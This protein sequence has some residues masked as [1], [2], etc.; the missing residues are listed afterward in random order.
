MAK[1]VYG[2]GSVTVAV[3]GTLERT[4]RD[5]VRAASRGIA[6]SI[7][8]LVDEVS[9]DAKQDWYDQ[10]DKRTGKSQASIT[11]EMRITTDKVTGV[12]YA[13]QKATYMIRRPG[14]LST[15]SSRRVADPREYFE[16]RDYYRKNGR[17]P[18]GYTYARLDS[19][20]DP[21]AVRKLRPNP[22]A[23]DG[24]SMW[25]ENVLKP[26]KKLITKNVRSI[27]KAAKKAVKGAS[28]G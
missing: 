10:V 21:V 8:A 16:V 9:E 23:S 25:T 28:R 4:L 18:E 24:K 22:K 5:A 17:M 13:S 27:E 20:G 2:S 11:P 3:D 6:D 14:P 15:L 26:G 19:A 1:V 7:E 12:V